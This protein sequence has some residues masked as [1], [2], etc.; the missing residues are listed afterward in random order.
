MC[1]EG[2][3]PAGLTRLE[4]RRALRLGVD[5]PEA[6]CYWA[7]CPASS[8]AWWRPRAQPLLP[9]ERGIGGAR[10]SRTVADG[11]LPLS[12]MP[13]AP[14]GGWEAAIVIPN[15][16]GRPEPQQGGPGDLLAG[17]SAHRASDPDDDRFVRLE[18]WRRLALVMGK[19]CTLGRQLLDC[20]GLEEEQALVADTLF[21]KATNTLSRRACS[22]SLFFRWL[23]DARVDR[24]LPVEEPTLYAYV[25]ALAAD[26]AP[27]TRAQG[28]LEALF[29]AEGAVGLPVMS[30]VRSSARVKGACMKSYERKR[31]TRK[32]RALMA[33]EVVALERF[34]CECKDDEE[35]V[36]AE[37][38]VIFTRSRCA[39]ASGVRAEP[40][41]DV[42]L[43]SD[44]AY[45]YIEVTAPKVK[46]TKG[47]KR[48]RLGIPI[49]GPAAGLWRSPADGWASRWLQARGRCFY[50][51]AAGQC[52]M[53]AVAAG[54]SQPLYSTPMSAPQLTVT[55]R[56]TLRRLG[57]AQERVAEVSSHS[58]KATTLS[59]C[60]K[61]N[62][63]K[64]SRRLL[65]GHIK[66]G[67]KSVLEYS[68]DGLAGPLRELDQVLE[69]IRAGKFFPDATRSGR[70]RGSGLAAIA[71][72]GAAGEP[73]EGGAAGADGDAEAEADSTSSS[74]DES[75]GDADAAAAEDEGLTALNE[76][77][78]EA[79]DDFN[80]STITYH[81]SRSKVRHLAP[82]G[83]IKELLCGRVLGPQFLVGGC[84]VQPLC[85]ACERVARRSATEPPESPVASAAEPSPV[86]ALGPSAEGGESDISTP[87]L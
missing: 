46:T 84:Q 74:S 72:A 11:L 81:H 65:G 67:E 37:C 16:L 7:A 2:T 85:K 8:F 17:A 41:L 59:W 45:G 15:A 79:R 25:K 75:S 3:M 63:A 29:F 12:P 48:R 61:A 54:G 77:V 23:A 62:V 87:S 58:L 44:G 19:H 52:L 47:I 39:D 40:Q 69:S 20:K 80:K 64:H 1:M 56:N 30:S 73:A 21:T 6:P 22:W 5:L 35:V 33:E 26:G 71:D 53:P 86:G 36:A 76:V 42:G 51:A 14:P 18:Q 49:V 9:W 27:A 28:F 38:F 70:W 24:S 34:V 60:A 31:L 32:A 43:A 4:T 50:R 13:T 55:L 57:F 66:P 82:I 78:G 68:R 83:G 10:L